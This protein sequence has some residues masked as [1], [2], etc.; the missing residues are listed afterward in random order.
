MLLALTATATLSVQ[1]EI[2]RL[3][4]IDESQV[5]RTSWTREN[6]SLRM[7]CL[8]SEFQRTERLA[9]LLQAKGESTIV[10]V[11]T[12]Y[13]TTVLAERLQNQYAIQ[14]CAAYHA[15]LSLVERKSIQE[16]FLADKLRVII[17]TVAYVFTSLFSSQ[18]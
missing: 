14:N 6:L 15:G 2:C 1:A 16:R 18:E 12:K 13:E 10:Y 5:T 4:R 8:E 11:S 3:L 9:L 17:A 7:A